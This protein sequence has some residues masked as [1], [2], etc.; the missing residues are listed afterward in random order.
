MPKRRDL[1]Q[2]RF[3]GPSRLCSWCA[4]Y[5][6]DCS[7]SGPLTQQA[8]ASMRSWFWWS[9][10]QGPKQPTADRA[11]TAWV[12]P[13]RRPL[14]WDELRPPTVQTEA[15]QEVRFICPHC[16]QKRAAHVCGKVW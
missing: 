15:M 7:C 16:K 13:Y 8:I 10:E 12:V 3:H 1:W 6:D 9:S 11:G 2:L 4:E 14:T 5:A